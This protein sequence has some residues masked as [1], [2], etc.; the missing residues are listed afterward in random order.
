[1]TATGT[2]PP[3]PAAS[4][5]ATRRTADVHRNPPWQL[6]VAG[7]ASLAILLF[8]GVGMVADYPTPPGTHTHTTG[9][10]NPQ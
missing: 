1:M 5:P 3:A 4:G 6:I 10:P 9:H 8:T 7:L 2:G